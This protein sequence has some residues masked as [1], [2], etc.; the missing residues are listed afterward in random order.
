MTERR[1]ATGS[2]VRAVIAGLWLICVAPP[3]IAQDTQARLAELLADHAWHE[4]LALIDT[5]LSSSPGDARWLMNRGNVLF[6]LNRDTDAL[7]VF[8]QVLAANPRSP[9]AYNNMA[10]ILAANGRYADAIQALQRAMRTHPVY[11]T[12]YENLTD[13]YAHLAGDAYR[14]ALQ[15]E[16]APE[17]AEPELTMVD[18]DTALASLG[19]QTSPAGANVQSSHAA[20]SV[21]SVDARPTLSALR[22]ASASPRLPSTVAPDDTGVRA[23]L[24]TWAS[25]WSRRDIAAYAAAYVSDF[26]GTHAD[27][28]TWLRERTARILPRDS[29]NVQVSDITVT[30]QGNRAAVSFTQS[31]DSAGLSLRSRKSMIL[32]SVG[33]QWLITQESGR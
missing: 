18:D 24:Q 7:A 8:D 32:Q 17:L 2:P 13:L 27:H 6:S 3:A 9:A 31:Y 22:A 21:D 23:A 30:S 29:I 1:S 25:A 15:S 16:K 10:V 12:A 11:A 20:L 19:D 5:Q 26:K 4:A 28:E 14:K 33:G